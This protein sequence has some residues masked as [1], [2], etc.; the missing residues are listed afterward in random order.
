MYN[1]YVQN[2]LNQLIES[3]NRNEKRLTLE[4]SLGI[5]SSATFCLGNYLHLSVGCRIHLSH[6]VHGKVDGTHWFE[7]N[8]TIRNIIRYL[9]AAEFNKKLSAWCSSKD[10][11]AHQLVNVCDGQSD[12]RVKETPTRCQKKPQK[13]Q[14]TPI[15]ITAIERNIRLFGHS[16]LPVCFIQSDVTNYIFFS[17]CF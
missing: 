3:S 12:K 9:F 11:D 5:F 4:L 1:S 2:Q 8:D 17:E 7:L 14:Q 15:V 13:H 10:H 16:H 6:T